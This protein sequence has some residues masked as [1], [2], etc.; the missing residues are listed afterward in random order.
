MPK[1]RTDWREKPANDLERLFAQATPEQIAA[2]QATLRR[3][4]TATNWEAGCTV[5]RLAFAIENMRETPV[6]FADVA[7]EFR[8]PVIA[9]LKRAMGVKD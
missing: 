1:I 5:P 7:P 8:I 4:E 6:F 2:A 3:A 9:A